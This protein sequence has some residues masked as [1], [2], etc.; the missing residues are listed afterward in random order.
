MSTSSALGDDAAS[1]ESVSSSPC[2]TNPSKDHSTFVY[3]PASIVASVTSNGFNVTSP[4]GEMSVLSSGGVRQPSTVAVSE[5][6]PVLSTSISLVYPGPPREIQST[7]STV[8]V[9]SLVASS[10][11]SA[12]TEA[13]SKPSAAIPRPIPVG[14]MYGSRDIVT[15]HGYGSQ[16]PTCMFPS[17]QDMRSAMTYTCP[18]T[19]IGGSVYAG[20][21]GGV[22]GGATANIKEFNTAD[23]MAQ[24]YG[25][26]GGIN[27]V[28]GASNDVG[29]DAVDDTSS[30]SFM[31]L[32]TTNASN[33][34]S[35]RQHQSYSSTLFDSG[36]SSNVS[37]TAVTPAA[38]YDPWYTSG[39]KYLNPYTGSLP[40]PI[41]NK[42]SKTSKR[43]M[44][45]SDSP[46]RKKKSSSKAGNR[47]SDKLPCSSPLWYGISSSSFSTLGTS[48]PDMP[49]FPFSSSLSLSTSP[50]TESL[51]T[52]STSSLTSASTSIGTSITS[53]DNQDTFMASVAP[54]GFHD[55]ASQNTRPTSLKYITPITSLP[56]SLQSTTP[57]GVQ[58]ATIQGRISPVATP[59]TLPNSLLKSHLS[60][61]SA[62]NNIDNEMNSLS[63]DP[64]WRKTLLRNIQ[65]MSLKSQAAGSHTTSTS[66]G[67]SKATPTASSTKNTTKKPS[68]AKRKDGGTTPSSNRKPSLPLELNSLLPLAHGP[69]F[70]PLPHGST[71]HNFSQSWL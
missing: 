16:V 62:G 50:Y 51:T 55:S 27:N 56:P 69:T 59:T 68:K 21:M 53:S 36:I 7:S 28:G 29:G 65:Q 40:D 57:I 18:S 61:S 35:Q 24:V 54:I 67:S 14:L 4:A 10:A 63:T 12:L 49:S 9:S 64:V 17:G 60:T 6:P 23:I 22:L 58:S 11:S 30:L 39:L 71:L 41:D 31:G 47:G 1:T 43:K 34:G 66:L 70:Y 46:S 25:N 52:S 19:T 45:K 38:C 3:H 37:N 20:N 15:L 13:T 5:P 33:E 48:Y 26:V 32:R 44:P 42:A 8:S 2:S